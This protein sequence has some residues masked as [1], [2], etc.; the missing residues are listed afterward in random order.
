MPSRRSVASLR[1]VKS[2]S[3]VWNQATPTGSKRR[4]R[5]SSSSSRQSASAR[6][7]RRVYHSASPWEK[8]RSRVSPPEPERIVPGPY[9]STRRTAK[10]RRA[11]SRA[12]E[13]PKTP[14][15]TTTALA[16]TAPGRA[17]SVAG[18]GGAAGAPPA[19]RRSGRPSARLLDEGPQRLLAAADD[20]IAVGE[21]EQVEVE[22]KQGAV[23]RAEAGL[24][25]LRLVHVGVG[26][27]PVGAG[28][29]AVGRD[30]QGALVRT[31]RPDLVG[32]D[33][34]R[35]LLAER[36]R[37]HR[38]AS[39]ELVHALADA[40]HGDAE[41]L[42]ERPGVAVVVAVREDDVRRRAALPEPRLALRGQE[43]VDQHPLAL[44]VVRAD[45]DPD[46]RVRR[47]PVP[48]TG[49]D[50][51]HRREPTASGPA[52]EGRP[53]PAQAAASSAARRLA[54]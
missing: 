47:R 48:E 51:L 17:G 26:D 11:S 2:P 34:P 36:E 13:A 54:T 33:A 6:R 21:Q 40:V 43:R 52:A 50:L 14:A 18:G 16:L 12:V 35:Q 28:E 15:P 31:D 37:R 30:V 8:R 9:C 4:V 46:P 45:R 53:A 20:G 24:R 22:P 38:A 10:P 5:H 39:L 19:P 41:R 42:A 27:D 1:S 44:E 3:R 32:A 7:A 25:P 23:G 49:G 29:R